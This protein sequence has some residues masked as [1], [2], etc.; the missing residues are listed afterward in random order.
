MRSL[1]PALDSLKEQTF[2]TDRNER[3]RFIHDWK[4]SDDQKILTVFFFHKDSP[5]ANLSRALGERA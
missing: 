4:L 3:V 2:L 1:R 5:Y